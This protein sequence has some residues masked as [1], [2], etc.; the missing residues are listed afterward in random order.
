MQKPNYAMQWRKEFSLDGEAMAAQMLADK[1]FLVY[2]SREHPYHGYDLMVYPNVA[3]EV[4]TS[5]LRTVNQKAKGYQFNLFRVGHSKRIHE[6][7]VML[8]CL[9]SYEDVVP[10]I[11]PTEIVQHKNSLVIPTPDPLMYA[12][13]WWL[14]RNAFDRIAQAGGV[15]FKQGRVTED[16][17]SFM[18]AHNGGATLP[19]ARN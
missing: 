14:Y 19:H 16:F 5:S 17:K 3:V 9:K 8:L 12:K 13:K 11:I 15:K 10:F 7:I 18:E 2:F 1:G 4:K 6:P